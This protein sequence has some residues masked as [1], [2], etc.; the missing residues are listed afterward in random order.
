MSSDSPIIKVEREPQSQQ[1][2]R[3]VQTNKGKVNLDDYK[4]D[5]VSKIMA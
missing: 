4:K 1:K 5:S 3:V 2:K